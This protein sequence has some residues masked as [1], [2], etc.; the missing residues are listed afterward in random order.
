MKFQRDGEGEKSQQSEN[1]VRSS[2]KNGKQ[3]LQMI[4]S[5]TLLHCIIG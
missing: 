1:G 5:R 2:N 4:H 3:W